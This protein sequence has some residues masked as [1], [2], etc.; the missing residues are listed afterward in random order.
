[1][2][3]PVVGK[4]IKAFKKQHDDEPDLGDMDS[5]DEQPEAEDK[6]VDKE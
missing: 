2:A 3:I 1:M 4:R 6:P 5:D